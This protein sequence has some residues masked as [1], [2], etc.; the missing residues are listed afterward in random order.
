MKLQTKLWSV[1]RM[2][3]WPGCSSCM[4]WPLWWEWCQKNKSIYS[5]ALFPL[6][7]LMRRELASIYAMK[8]RK[9]YLKR[10]L[11]HTLRNLS[12]YWRFEFTTRVNNTSG[13]DFSPH[14][15][16]GHLFFGAGLTHLLS[17]PRHRSSPSQHKGSLV[18]HRPS[19]ASR[20][21]HGEVF[22]W[23]LLRGSDQSC[24]RFM[25]ITL[26]GN[27]DDHPRF[28]GACAA[29]G[30]R[31][32]PRNGRVPQRSVGVFVPFWPGFRW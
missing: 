24:C 28:S 22:Y 29:Q 14:L 27:R 9:N 7:G 16:I 20:C 10:Q 18:W 19:W 25:M 17:E 21:H 15:H 8:Q 3:L 30:G 13:P 11:N 4:W 2:D 32:C 6:G 23:S 12:F 31:V 26:V 5:S 1:L